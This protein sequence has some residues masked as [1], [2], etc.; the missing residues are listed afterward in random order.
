MGIE[1]R[2]NPKEAQIL[3]VSLRKQEGVKTRR[4][5]LL[6]IGCCLIH[7]QNTRLTLEEED[8]WFLRDTIDPT[9]HVGDASG[10]EL[11]KRIYEALL[12]GYEGIPTQDELEKMF[13][14]EGIKEAEYAD[15]RSTRENEDYA[16]NPAEG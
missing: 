10:I 13:E 11:I 9:V 12:V 3:E 1:F 2:I 5:L 4:E 15:G 7:Q 14:K 6:D 8:L 16:S